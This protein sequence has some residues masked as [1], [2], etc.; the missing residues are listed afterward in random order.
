[1]NKR[2]N[3]RT[4]EKAKSA[5]IFYSCYLKAREDKEYKKLKEEFQNMH[6]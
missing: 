4:N 1:M 3:E 5:R 2:T 6:G